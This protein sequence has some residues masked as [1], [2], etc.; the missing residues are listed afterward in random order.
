MSTF[1]TANI[2]NIV[3]LSHSGAGKTMLA[4]SIL[5]STNLVSR[6]GSIEEGTTTSD[7]EPEEIRRQSSV[8]SSIIPCIWNQTKINILDTPGYADFRGDVIS[9]LNVAD[10]AIILVSASAG[11]EVGTVQLWNMVQKRKIPCAF[12]ISKMDRE[13]SDHKRILGEINSEFGKNCVPYNLPV[14]KESDL[15]S[16]LNVLSSNSESISDEMEPDVSQYSEQLTEL[17]AETDDALVNKYLEGNPLTPDEIGKGL[18]IGIHN[19]SIV[20]ILFGS[21][22]MGIG[23]QELLDFISLNLPSPSENIPIIAENATSGDEIQLDY[24]SD[25]D[26]SAIV[27]KTTADPF[28]GKLSYFKVLSGTLSSDS[29]V[30]NVSKKTNEKI[31]QTFTIRGKNQEPINSVIAGDIGAVSKL[32]TVLTNDYLSTESNPIILPTIQ[33]PQPIYQMAVSPKSRAD[34]DKMTSSLSRIG[35]EDPT[36]QIEREQSTGETLLNGLGDTHLEVSIERMKRKFGVEMTLSLPKVPYKETIT[37]NSKVEYRHKKQSGGR[38]QFGHVWLELEP[39]NRGEGFEF[40]DKIVGGSVPKEYIPAVEKGVSKILGE[41][42][43]AG[44]PIVDIK[45]TL[46]DGSFHPVD[47]SGVCFEIAGGQAFSNGMM[48]ATPALLEPIMHAEITVPDSCTGDIIG[49][50]NSKRGRIQGM[51]PLGEG[52]TTVE[53]EVPR[54][55]MLKYATDL[56]S[57]TQGRGEFKTEFGHY[58]MVPHHLIEEIVANLKKQAEG[59]VE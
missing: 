32:N 59:I 45:V 52:L 2:R 17:I 24:D 9:S 20:P 49:D 16:V 6:L 54:A 51:N 19:N 11:I 43:L 8:Q 58:E 46:F 13:N 39:K 41:G 44:F 31:A 26:L 18:K 21:S 34:V 3:L 7:Y 23:V 55:E 12:F 38:G 42:V 22:T 27:F 4:E 57:M 25:A 50:L 1:T 28:V 53:A 56:R 40:A 30:W 29:E 47:S 36:L 15:S 14:G 35:D 48:S 10:S 33:F 37:A 5:F